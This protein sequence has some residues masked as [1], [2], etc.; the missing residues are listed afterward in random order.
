[1]FETYINEEDEVKT[2]EER[3]VRVVPSVMGL[4]TLPDGKRV[5]R[6]SESHF[7]K[8]NL[9]RFSPIGGAESVSLEGITELSDAVG[10]QILYE[11]PQTHQKEGMP[12]LSE[13]PYPN[14]HGSDY[15]L[16]VYVAESQM[17]NFSAW[18]ESTELRQGVAGIVRECY[19]ELALEARIEGYDPVLPELTEQS[20][21]ATK[22]GIYTDVSVSTNPDRGAAGRVT[23]YVF[24]TYDLQLTDEMVAKLT[25]Q[26]GKTPYIAALSVAELQAI[27][28]G[29]SEITEWYGCPVKVSADILNMF[30]PALVA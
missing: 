24:T 4:L 14:E 13:T 7:L 26:V 15:D 9:S 20:I 16:R 17:D 6:L 21:S 1:M 2:T 28:D 27:L 3:Y 19:E 11:I 30:D 8:K 22:I 29:D 10:G 5:Q 18:M 25:D 12:N 23:H